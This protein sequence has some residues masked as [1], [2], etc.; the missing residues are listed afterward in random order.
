MVACLNASLV[1]NNP[2]DISDECEWRE[3]EREREGRGG[4]GGD[5]DG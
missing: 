3:E 4:G 2:L 1:V 5:K